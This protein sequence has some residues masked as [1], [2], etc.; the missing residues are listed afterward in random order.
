MALRLLPDPWDEPGRETD[1]DRI[2][3]YGWPVDVACTFCGDTG[4]LPGTQMECHCATGAALYTQTTRRALWPALIPKRFHDYTLAGHPNRKLAA[5]VGGWVDSHPVGSGENIVI[6]GGVGT[7]KTGAAIAALRELF[8]TGSSILY[9]SLPDL[10]DA[11]RAE[12][13]SRTKGDDP[14]R[15]VPTM[16]QLT[17]VDVL[18]LDDMGTERPTAYVTDRLFLIVDKRYGEGKPT[19]V[20]TNVVGGGFE[21]YLGDRIA[22]RL[23]EC[24]RVIVAAG[25]DLRRTK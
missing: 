8:F 16:G 10:M 19:V 4:K 9:W 22:S 12:E 3:K 5:D 17:N 11:L 14:A 25:P 18:L 13:F 2:E 1:A 23:R 21:K 7:G 6:Q 15:P 20:T 24:S